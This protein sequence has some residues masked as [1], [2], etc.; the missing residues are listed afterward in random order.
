M[1]EWKVEK[2]EL[3]NCDAK[4]LSKLEQ[5]YS[6]EDKIA[7]VDSMQDG[8]LSYLL[9]LIAKFESEQDTLP[10]DKW[11]YVKTV[12]LKAWLKR[13]DSQKIV[14]DKYYYGEFSFLGVKRY[15][16]NNAW[17][18]KNHW[19]T[20][21]SLVDEIF[22][23]QV[24]KCVEMERKYF[25][26]HD[27]YSIL[28]KELAKSHSEYG[29]TFGVKINFWSKGEICIVKND[30]EERPITIEEIK[31]LLEKYRELNDLIL[32]LTSEIHITY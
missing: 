12:S 32:K 9:N 7:F 31:L 26:E 13:N 22:H 25:I 16:T 8:K 2:L 1:F 30:D 11:G 15:I 6:R 3:L 24:L 17:D 18:C 23:R 14:D 19:D 27:E 29:T 5:Q 21:F 20:H 28:K 4:T 10:K